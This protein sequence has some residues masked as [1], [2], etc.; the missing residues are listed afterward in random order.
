MYRAKQK[1]SEEMICKLEKKGEMS[2]DGRVDMKDVCT[3]VSEHSTL[4]AQKDNSTRDCTGA[5]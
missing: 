2:Q 3:I 5:E 4:K 1:E